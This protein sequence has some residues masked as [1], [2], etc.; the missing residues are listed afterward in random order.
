MTLVLTSFFIAF[1]SIQLLQKAP[2]S[3]TNN[4]NP[5]DNFEVF[6]Y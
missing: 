2:S 3:N 4:N 5:I 1:K 6:N